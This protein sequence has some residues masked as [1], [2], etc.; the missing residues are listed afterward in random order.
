M[1]HKR[2]EMEDRIE[3]V[4]RGVVFE[5]V[6]AI[7][8]AANTSLLGGGGVDGAIHKGAGT[9]LLEECKKLGGCQ[10]GQA[11]ITKGYNLPCKFII[12]TV[13]PVYHTGKRGEAE[14]LA[15]AYRRSLEVAHDNKLKTISFP[16]ISCGVYGYPHDEAAEIAIKTAAEQLD[17]FT[18]IEFVRFVLFSDN[19]FNVFNDVLAKLKQQ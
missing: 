12:H 13:G 4:D 15:S 2:D 11:K 16:A 19:I 8:N 1:S 14:Q 7:I 5:E 18:E 10:T 3:I 17:K 9:D 6:D